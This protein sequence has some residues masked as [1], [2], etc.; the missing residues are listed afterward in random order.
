VIHGRSPR[1]AGV[2]L[3]A[4]AGRFVVA[5]CVL[6]ALS[7]ARHEAEGRSRDL[8]TSV[9]RVEIHGMKFDPPVVTAAVNDTVRWNNHDIVPHNTTALDGSWNSGSIGPDSSWSTVM[10][11]PGAVDYT[12][13]FHPAMKAR[14]TVR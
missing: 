14:I 1:S 6:A 8:G 4:G 13:T 9:R 12:C 11:K 7:C 5:A 3:A 2:R 10:R